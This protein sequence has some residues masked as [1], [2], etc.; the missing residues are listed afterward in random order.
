MKSGY[1]DRLAEELYLQ[2]CEAE[3]GVNHPVLKAWS[4][5]EDTFGQV[6]FGAKTEC[7]DKLFRET[8]R[9]VIDSL[10][11]TTQE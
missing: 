5:C 10:E 11:I 4:E 8:I 6:E 1:N 9:Y 3:G 2:F 7:I